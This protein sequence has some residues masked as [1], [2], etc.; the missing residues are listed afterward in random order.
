MSWVWVSP[1][2]SHSVIS[3]F[4]H[5]EW[6]K[7]TSPGSLQAGHKRADVIFG[8]LLIYFHWILPEKYYKIISQLSFDISD[9]NCYY[10]FKTVFNC[11]LLIDC[12][13]L[14][15]C[16]RLFAGSL[17]AIILPQS[18]PKILWVPGNNNP[19]SNRVK[20]WMAVSSLIRVVWCA[21]IHWDILGAYFWWRNCMFEPQLEMLKM[22]VNYSIQTYSGKMSPEIDN[23]WSFIPHLKETAF[24]LF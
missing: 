2:Y 8:Y 13:W 16:S 7:H 9:R 21:F 5:A 17:N 1:S 6:N 23:G 24:Y 19:E 11:K 20:Q 4:I 14:W 18:L 12:Y 15:W 10:R 22:N 3:G